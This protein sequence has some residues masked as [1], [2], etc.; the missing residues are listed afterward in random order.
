MKRRIYRILGM[1]AV[2]GMTLATMSCTDYLETDKYFKDMQS[3][4]HVFENKDN[5]NQFLAYVYS[6][7]QGDNVEIGHSDICP[8]NFCDDQ[9]FNEGDNGQRYR[10]FKLGEYGPGYNLYNTWYQQAWPWSYAAIRQASIFIDNIHPTEDIPEAEATDLRGQARFLRAYFYWL[11]IKKYGPVPLMPESGADYTKSYDELSFPRNTYDECVEFID[12][13]MKKAATELPMTRDNMS[14]ARPTKG[15]ALAVRAKVLTYAASPL[16]NGNT[17][18]ADFKDKNGRQLISQTYD[19]S[20]WAKAAAACR[21]LI[22]YSEANKVYRIYTASR[23]TSANDEARPVTI[24][25]PTCEPYSSR[26]FPEGWADIDPFESY[27]SVFNGELLATENPEVIFTRG[28]NADNTDSKTAY[29]IA[30]LV[31]HQLPTSLGGYNIHGVTQKQCDAYAMADGSPYDRS[32]LEEWYEGQEFT[33]ATNGNL[34]PYDHLRNNGVW[35]GYANREPRFYASVAYSGSVWNGLS[36]KDLIY[37]NLQIFY[38]RGEADGRVNAN[39]RWCNT[40]I[41]VM[42]YVHPDDSWRG[43]DAT[44]R[45]KLEPTLRYADILLLYAEALNN[46]T[47]TYEIPSWDGSKT[48]SISRDVKEMHRVVMPIRMRAGVPDYSDDVYANQKKF[49]EAIV[50]ERQIEFFGENQRYFDIR[51][52]KIAPENESEQIYGCNTLMNKEH[53]HE[54]YQKVRV[55]NLQTSFSRKQYFWPITYDELKR[56]KNMTQAPGWQDYD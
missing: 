11:L 15:A 36:S 47:A 4:E 52:W 1:A 37:R 34:H 3:I 39:E 22:E 6:R 48:Y 8:T 40:G 25:P 21:D 44:I 55:P 29:G 33:T 41:G 28:K 17:E 38:Y 31:A 27:R 30:D 10:Q 23:R 14:I 54:F 35:L 53:A 19:E 16:Y 45:M 5:T 49:F 18:F 13:E 24:T 43:T 32:K 7:L 9:T 2:A 51:R 56:N 20:K 12:K 42:K 46:L 26:N 50:H